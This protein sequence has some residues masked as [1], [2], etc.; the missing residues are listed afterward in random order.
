MAKH[1]EQSD[2]RAHKVKLDYHIVGQ[3]NLRCAGCGQNSPFR[4]KDLT[5]LS[6]FEEDVERLAKIMRV[7]TLYLLGGEPLLHPEIVEFA[8]VARRAGLAEQ[9]GVWTN[10]LLLARQPDDFWAEF[11]TIAISLYPL[12]ERS[13]K[14][15][16]RDL[17]SRKAKEH[18]TG[19]FYLLHDEFRE[20][21]VDYPIEDPQLVSDIYQTCYKA[22]HCHVVRNGRYYRCPISHSLDAYL[23]Q[24]GYDTDF[25]TEDGL[26]LED[27]PDMLD[28]IHDFLKGEKALGA[29]QFCLGS[30]G[31]RFAHRQLTHTEVKNPERSV[32]VEDALDTRTLKRMKQFMRLERMVAWTPPYKAVLRRKNWEAIPWLSVIELKDRFRKKWKAGLLGS[33]R[34]T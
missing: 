2:G 9:V 10:G 5:P 15:L 18:D 3:C 30:V 23:Q 16:D 12:D 14:M 21:L 6:V 27:R 4:R 20:A 13:Q 1:R 7:D 11:D 32:R 28:R 8:R 25:A 17:I 26:L 33:G 31:N 22:V 34:R 19:L 24:I 29:C